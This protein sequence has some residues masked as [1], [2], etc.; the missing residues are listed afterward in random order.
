MKTFAITLASL[1][2]VVV[3]AIAGIA[4]G[5][6]AG[7]TLTANR[8]QASCDNESEAKTMINGHAYFCG[9]F[10]SVNRALAAL[11]HQRGA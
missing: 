6:K 8:I 10:D 7:E 1:F 11:Q 9:D 5:V 4:V 3:V 2:F